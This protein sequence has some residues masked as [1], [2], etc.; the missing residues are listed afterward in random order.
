MYNVMYTL[1]KTC[2]MTAKIRKQIYIEADQDV[3]LK[4]LVHQK[5]GSEAEIIRQAIA[6]YALSFQSP[7][8]DLSAWEQERAFIQNLMAQGPIQGE[9]TWQREDLHER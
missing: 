1:V 4:Q 3:L 8:L 7:T 5:G 9:R 2:T 6:Q